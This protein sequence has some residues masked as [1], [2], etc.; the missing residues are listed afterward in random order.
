[1]P[2]LILQMTMKHHDMSKEDAIS[3]INKQSQLFPAE[4]ENTLY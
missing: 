4:L 1:M 3:R 2:E